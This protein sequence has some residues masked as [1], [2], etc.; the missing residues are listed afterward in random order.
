M[1]L[2]KIVTCN[3]RKMTDFKKLIIILFLMLTLIGCFKP[4][5]EIPSGQY[6]T[7]D[8]CHTDELRLYSNGTFHIIHTM[9][10]VGGFHSTYGIYSSK[11]GKLRFQDDLELFWNK[12]LV[13]EKD[14][15]N[16]DS[17]FISFKEFI[18]FAYNLRNDSAYK[19]NVY[20]RDSSGHKILIFKSYD[21][22][23]QVNYS[24]IKLAF[25][26]KEIEGL[27]N[28][29]FEKENEKA[30]FDLLLKEFETATSIVYPVI[31]NWRR[32]EFKENHRTFDSVYW[33]GKA[34]K[35]KYIFN[36]YYPGF[37]PRKTEFVKINGSK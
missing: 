30:G 3:H 9:C 34:Y 35:D 26:K 32:Q 20:G 23:Q 10:D 16:V 11:N 24:N 8:E 12:H 7:E 21:G 14:S 18:P 19:F 5:I 22:I 29:W 37:E 13:V 28:I 6:F 15:T 27:K 25:S 2:C 1:F 31:S 33:T 36:V 4:L 17:L